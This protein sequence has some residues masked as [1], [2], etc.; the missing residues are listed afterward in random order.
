MHIFQNDGWIRS[1]TASEKSLK[2]YQV[3]VVNYFLNLP[4]PILFVFMVQKGNF[5]L[6]GVSGAEI[7]F[8]I[9]VFS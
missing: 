1:L 2:F 8:P 4:F 5:N 7:C 6:W 9:C 3:T